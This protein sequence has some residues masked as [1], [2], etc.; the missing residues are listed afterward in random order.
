MA[1]YLVN[2]NLTVEID[3]SG[4]TL[5]DISAHVTEVGDFGKEVAEVDDTVI[6]DTAESII[7]GIERSQSLTIGGFV[8]DTAST[9]SDTVLSGIVG[10]IGTVKITAKSSVRSFQ[11]EMLCT[12]YKIMFS[13]GD[14]SRFQAT[15]RQDGAVTVGT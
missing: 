5:R 9:G 14:Y 8:D 6:S 10:S 2:G 13:I 4:G 3:D 7:T 11:A 15:F 12:S 1:K